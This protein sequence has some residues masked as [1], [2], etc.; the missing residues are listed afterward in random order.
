MLI[1]KEGEKLQTLKKSC[2]RPVRN[3]MTTLMYSLIHNL[4]IMKMH[5]CVIV[6]DRR[7]RYFV[8]LRHIFS[9]NSV[10]IKFIHKLIFIHNLLSRETD[11]HL[12]E[13]WAHW[14]RSLGFR[15]VKMLNRISS[16][17]SSIFLKIHSK[18]WSPWRLTRSILSCL[19]TSIWQFLK[20]RLALPWAGSFRQFARAVGKIK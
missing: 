6:A 7:P 11:L 13:T 5:R 12:P 8:P 14:Q 15:N 3:L 17:T 18:T 20:C 10:E 1:S 4:K 19:F 2:T 16:G 9:I